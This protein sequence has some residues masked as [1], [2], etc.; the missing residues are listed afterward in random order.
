MKVVIDVHKEYRVRVVIVQGRSMRA[1]VERRG[2]T[3]KIVP[4]LMQALGRIGGVAKITE[5]AVISGA[6]FSAARTAAVV[7]NVLAFVQGLPLLS[8]HY[9][10]PPN[11]G[12]STPA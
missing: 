6:S 1:V 3:D 9:S 11:I 7:A 2:R 5:I 10:A 4:A 8:A 12:G